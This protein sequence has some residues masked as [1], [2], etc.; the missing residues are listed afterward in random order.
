MMMPLMEIEMSSMEGGGG[1]KI[2]IRK[3]RLTTSTERNGTILITIKERKVRSTY[4]FILLKQ[5][6]APL[7][8]GYHGIT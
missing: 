3:S 2:S 6:K 1:K 5:C 8:R 7:S 4:P